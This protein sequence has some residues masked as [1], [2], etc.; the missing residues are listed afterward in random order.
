L[1][2]FI[3]YCDKLTDDMANCTSTPVA[4]LKGQAVPS[5]VALQ[6]I[7]GPLIDKVGEAQVDFGNAWEDMFN[8]ACSMMGV[9]AD[10]TLEWKDAFKGD[11]FINDMA[12]YK[13]GLISKIRYH[14]RRGLDEAEATNIVAEVDAETKAKAEEDFAL[15]QQAAQLNPV[16]PAKVF[17]PTK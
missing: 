17:P 9:E 16:I 5:G 11:S 13:A 6:E 4:Y 12:E 8:L 1:T 3:A 10:V 15:A 2:Q 7:A 14:M